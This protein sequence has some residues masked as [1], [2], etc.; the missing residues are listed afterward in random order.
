MSLLMLRGPVLAQGAGAAAP[1]VDIGS[2]GELDATRRPAGY[3][4]SDG[5]R[6]AI[7]TSGGSDYR[8]WVPTAKVLLP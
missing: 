2:A 7:N 8:R 4:L 5:N 3:T 1:P 6:T